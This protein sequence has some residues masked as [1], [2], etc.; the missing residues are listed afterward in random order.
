LRLRHPEFLKRVSRTGMNFCR[1]FGLLA[2]TTQP[3]PELRLGLQNN[4]GTS[5]I[6]GANVGFDPGSNWH[7]IPHHDLFG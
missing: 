7:V 6:S 1:L 5:R 2:R 4:N 3:I